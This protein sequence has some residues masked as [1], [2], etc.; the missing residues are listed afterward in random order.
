MSV[1]L[2]WGADDLGDLK[3]L[4][5]ILFSLIMM[6]A[7][8]F[9]AYYTTRWL[10]S[11]TAGGRGSS[12]IKIL[13]R[14]LLSQDKTLVILDVAGQCMLLGITQQSIQKI[15]DLDAGRLQPSSGTEPFPTIFLEALKG[16]IGM[17]KDGKKDRGEGGTS[18]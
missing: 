10:G 15:C 14:L 7:V 9:A 2:I 4:F 13:D 11:K 1:D 6:V 18:C 17:E 12:N 5:S 16:K 8:L 3:S